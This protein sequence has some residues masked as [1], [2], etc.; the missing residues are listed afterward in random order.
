MDSSTN[1]ESALFTVLFAISRISGWT[2]RCLEYRAHNRIMRPR[3][4]YIGPLS[5]AYVPLEERR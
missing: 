5:A 1:I 4:S 2:A 3:A